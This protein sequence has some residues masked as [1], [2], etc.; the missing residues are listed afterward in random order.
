MIDRQDKQDEKTQKKMKDA[1]KGGMP[2]L[3]LVL[4]YEN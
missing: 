4:G 2:T 1:P 3:F